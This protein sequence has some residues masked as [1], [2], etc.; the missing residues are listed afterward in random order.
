MGG[1][2]AIHVDHLTGNIV[3]FREQ[4]AHRASDVPRTA[5]T[6]QQGVRDDVVSRRVV[7]GATVRPQNRPRRH[8]VH[9]YLWRQFDGQGT[10][11]PEQSRFRRTVQRITGERTF[12]MDVTILRLFNAYGPG[13]SG[14]FLVPTIARQAAD[15]EVAEIV[16][17]VNG[18]RART[19][20]NFAA[21]SL[22]FTSALQEHAHA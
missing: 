4:I 5:G 20:T 6:L 17:I 14:N 13:Q 11:Q 19:T 1:T 12:G 8:R 16:V 2:T 21:S 15:P 3:C 7:K 18:L 10:R 9:A 22:P